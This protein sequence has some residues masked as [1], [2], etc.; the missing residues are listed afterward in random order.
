MIKRIILLIIISFFIVGCSKQPTITHSIEFEKDV[1]IEYGD[2]VDSTQYIVSVDNITA[3]SNNKEGNKLYISTFYVECPDIDSSKLGKQNL[4][5]NIGKEEY[6]LTV[7]VKDTQPPKII[8]EKDN[9]EIEEGKKISLLDIRFSITDNCTPLK[10]IKLELQE[11]DSK[12]YLV[13]TDSS[14]NKSEKVIN[15]SVKKKKENNSQ[16]SNGDGS[17]NSSSGQQGNK[18]SKSSSQKKNES[19]GAQNTV[20]NGEKFYFKDGYDEGD[21]VSS[22]SK[23]GKS[24]TCVPIKDKE[25]KLFIGYQILFY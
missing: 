22:L 11:R 17:N 21:C 20:K 24:G 3:N 8:L 5:Y 19:S 25:G 12:T 14:K 6:S 18:D 4:I 13:A 2:K 7:T 1:V 23:S 9:Y 15:I 16:P 10:D